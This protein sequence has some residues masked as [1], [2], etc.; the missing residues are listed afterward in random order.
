M[1]YYVL[2][3]LYSYL[4]INNYSSLFFFFI[5]LRR[6]N[7][8]DGECSPD[9]AL[10]GYWNFIRHGCQYSLF[11][12]SVATTWACFGRMVHFLLAPWMYRFLLYHFLVILYGVKGGNGKTGGNQ[13]RGHG[14]VHLT[15]W[16]ISQIKKTASLCPYL[17][18]S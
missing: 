1:T 3:C 11:V 9:P 6:M 7:A 16:A 8:F 4:C 17:L 10:A 14:S 18:R 12:S 2:F 5:F 13:C 15:G